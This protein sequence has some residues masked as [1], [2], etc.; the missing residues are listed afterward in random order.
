MPVCI[1]ASRQSGGVDEPNK[2]ARWGRIAVYVAMVAPVLYA[3][4]RYAWAL[5]IPLGITEEYLRS[6]L[7]RDL[8]RRDLP[9]DLLPCGRVTHAGLVQHWGE[10][11]P[12]G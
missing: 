5:G 6:G 10:V 8:D 2:A 9:G 3:L 12:T 4:I 7:E 11:F 1:A